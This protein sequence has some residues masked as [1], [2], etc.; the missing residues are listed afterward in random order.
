[1]PKEIKDFV[2][3]I[4]LGSSKIT[5]IAG[6][7]NSDGSI[8]VLAYARED[9][10]S[11]IKRGMVYNIDK[12]AQCLNNIK[13]KLEKTLKA[14]VGKA[15]VGIAGQSL[16]TM[17]NSVN[18]PLA[19]GSII[20]KETIDELKMVNREATYADQELLQV[21][22]Q[23][24]VVGTAKL[25]DPVGVV[26]DNVE[27]R[28]L[29]IIARSSLRGNLLKSLN[30]AGIQV[31]EY[32][33]SPLALADCVLTDAEK[34][35]GCALVDFGAET[36]TVAV[37][38]N[39]ILR[40]LAVI[41]LGG[42]NITK[43]I[44]GLQIE[45]EDAEELKLKYGSAYNE[46]E[47]NTNNDDTK[48]YPV[49]D[50]R[51]IDACMLNAIVESR[52]EE[53]I[54]NIWEQIQQSSCG[55]EL[56]AGVVLTGGGSNLK[57]LELAFNKRTNIE[58]IR[59]AKF[60][61]QAI[62]AKNPDIKSKDGSLNTILAL[63]IKG[64]DNCFGVP[65]EGGDNLFDSDGQPYI[66]RKRAEEEERRRKLEEEE[67]KLRALEE[68]KARQEEEARRKEEEARLRAQQKENSFWNRMKKGFTKIIS[69]D[70]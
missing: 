26:A 42:H 29:N 33:I 67:A 65:L 28:Y 51:T 58:K 46:N 47:D 37:F 30:L 2:V 18:L 24:Y 54:A 70:D 35:S 25:V 69:E 1:M 14:S 17:K 31:A 27:G 13:Q 15:Y 57:N 56:L 55:N 50:E 36:T 16:H 53:I 9:S 8:T 41:P 3:A 64:K 43:D 11:F 32:F 52:V 62:D 6:K 23:E 34:R 22:P 48:Q 68:E 12:T 19:S 39:N 66:E 38:K 60:V 7:K 45:E 49:T 5:G 20:S 59:I 44:A 4:E 40:H 63:L 61:T 21:I 10:A